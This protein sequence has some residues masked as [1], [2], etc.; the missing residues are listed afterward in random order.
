MWA[1]AVVLL[2]LHRMDVWRVDGGKIRA[3]KIH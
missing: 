1:S 3:K 2:I